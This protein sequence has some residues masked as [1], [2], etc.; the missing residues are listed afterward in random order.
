MPTVGSRG[1][2]GSTQMRE[3]VEVR[4]LD[5]CH[6]ACLGAEDLCIEPDAEMVDEA[7]AYVGNGRGGYCKVDTFN[8]VGEGGGNYQKSVSTSGTTYKMTAFGSCCC[9]LVVVTVLLGVASV[10]LPH[11]APEFL[12]ALR[13]TVANEVADSL[14][15]PPAESST[16]TTARPEDVS[17]EYDCA[18]GDV[19]TWAAGQKAWC[20]EKFQAGCGVAFQAAPPTAPPAAPQMQPP[21]SM[22]SPIGQ[23][24]PPTIS[25]PP[26]PAAPPAQA[27]PATPVQPWPATPAKS[28]ATA[29]I[30]QQVGV[31][32]QPATTPKPPFDC[33]LGLEN[34]WLGW[35]DGK[36]AWCCQ[37]QHKGCAAGTAPAV[38]TVVQQPG[39][40]QPVAAAQPPQLPVAVGVGHGLAGHSQAAA[41]HVPKP[42]HCDNG[43]SSSWKPGKKAWC[44]KHETKG[45]PGGVPLATTTTGLPY[46]CDDGTTNW[47]AG[48][49]IMK[50]GW[51]CQHAGSGCDSD[52]DDEASSTKPAAA[53][54]VASPAASK[55]ASSHSPPLSPAAVHSAWPVAPTAT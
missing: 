2:A 23:T 18:R 19:S 5:G 12:P 13:E 32:G 11:M 31:G 3:L 35:S 48:W 38:G 51:C 27:A 26:L 25:P 15:L 54:A 47:K 50:K 22:L 55:E 1:T 14:G 53:A 8:F 45:C 9:F 36:K 37:F 42:Y 40:Q 10:V 20:C 52:S 17:F 24:V 41:G 43:L 7:W 21:P 30:F 29:P 46:N 33:N 44:C 28:V 16:S 39:A 6:N 4:R 34:S 49:S